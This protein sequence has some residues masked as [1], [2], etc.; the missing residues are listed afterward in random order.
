MSDPFAMALDVLFYA[1]GS[2]EAQYDSPV[3][4]IQTVR[5]IRTVRAADAPFGDAPVQMDAAV[6]EIRR[7]EVADPQ[8]GDTLVVGGVRFKLVGDPDLDVEGLTWRCEAP[9]VA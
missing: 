1:P 7:S 4:G 6:F 5:V 2:A 3:T 9:P 8:A